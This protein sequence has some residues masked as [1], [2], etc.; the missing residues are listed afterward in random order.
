[1]TASVGRNITLQWN[2]ATPLGVQEKDLGAERRSGG[3][4]VG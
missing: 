4:L 2:S 1:M 3:H